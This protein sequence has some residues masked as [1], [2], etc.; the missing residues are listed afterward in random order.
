MLKK[1]LVDIIETPDVVS[2]L[3]GS[4]L[5]VV[6]D[7][8]AAAGKFEEVDDVDFGELDPETSGAADDFEDP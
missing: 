1:P 6:K 5:E 3:K 4:K 2:P 8:F 7:T